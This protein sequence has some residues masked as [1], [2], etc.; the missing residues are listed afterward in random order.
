ML[1]FLFYTVYAVFGRFHAWISRGTWA[2]LFVLGLNAVLGRDSWGGW[3]VWAMILA[4]LGVD[5]PPPEDAHTPLDR[6]RTIA[7]A[8]TLVI[9]V[10]TFMQNPFTEAPPS[11]PPPPEFEGNRIPISVPAHQQPHDGVR[12]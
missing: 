1:C 8:L 7:A 3:M 11:A 12:L 2:F 9:F 10:L 5:H 4:V 6:R